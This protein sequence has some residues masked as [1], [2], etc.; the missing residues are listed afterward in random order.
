MSRKNGTRRPL[1]LVGVALAVVMLLSACADAAAPP[2]DVQTD[3]QADVQADVQTDEQADVQTD[4]QADVQADVPDVSITVYQG[5]IVLGGSE[6][7]LSDVFA[8]GRPVVLTVWA[9]L[10]PIC[11][12][13]MPELQIVHEEYGD[14]VI[15]LGIDI[16]TFV[17]LGTEDDARA[18]ISEFGI[19]FPNG[20]ISDVVLLN[21][22]NVIGVPTTVFIKPDG[23][24]TDHRSGALT[25]TELRAYVTELIA[26]SE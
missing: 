17:E 9:G 2:A 3:A 20:T 12:I 7:T 16:G 1:A 26:A 21:Y 4:E 10:C 18:L 24:I 5:E 22:Y 11:R 13:E 23:E 15:F 19:T 25:E 14:Q 8:Q 6:V